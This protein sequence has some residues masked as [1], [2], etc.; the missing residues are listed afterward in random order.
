[1]QLRSLL[2]AVTLVGTTATAHAQDPTG[3]WL[4]ENGEAVVRIVDCGGTLWGVVAWQKTPLGRDVHNPEPALRNRPTLGM[5][6]LLHMRRGE[7]PASW[8]GEI[9][10]ARN[11]KTYDATMTLQGADS[12][13]IEGCTLGVLCGGQDWQRVEPPDAITTGSAPAAPDAPQAICS[14]ILSGSGRPH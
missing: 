9:Y 1:M 11:G 8:E 12:L 13:Q 6:V 14:R 10:N 5:P 4:V 7:E 3:N 2:L